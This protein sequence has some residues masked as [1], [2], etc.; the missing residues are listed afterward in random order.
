MTGLSKLTQLTEQAEHLI[1]GLMSGTSL[2]GLD[3]ALCRIKGRGK[4]ATVTLEH[5][6]TY[7][8]TEALQRKIREIFAQEAVK[9]S[10]V[11]MLNSRIAI[12]HARM[13]LE[14]L[15]K[16]GV[17]PTEVDCIASHGQTIYHAPKRLHLKAHYSNS[18]LQIGDGDHLA[19]RTGIITISDFRQKHVAAGGEGAPLV[20]YGDYILFSD[21]S[22]D[23]IL[24]NIGGIAN[25]T[26]LPASQDATQVRATDT[27]PGNTLMD[28]A[29]RHYLPPL[30]FDDE[31][32]IAA[33]GTVQIDLLKTMKTHPF[34]LNS[35]PKTTGQELF[36]MKFFQD[37]Q[38]NSDTL[39]ISNADLLATLT[40][41]TAETI[42]DAIQ[43]Y[44]PNWQN[45]AIYLSGGG[46][47]NLTLETHLHELLQPCK[48]KELRT[49]GFPTHAKEAT[50]FALLAHQTL[51]S[52]VLQLGD[53]DNYIPAVSLGKISLPD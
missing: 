30:L 2:D 22:E 8:Y 20:V 51:T 7:P 26:Y 41:F 9:L 39:D 12:L 17:A 19:Y 16:W 34:F 38:R 5:F 6:S 27:G 23:R 48:F 53:K 32:T 42:A 14:T 45:C 36:N 4:E 28:T 46:A 24:L 43:E 44:I 50:L 47:K 11:C 35:F 10:T 18:T 3:I 25:L 33:A 40:R 29:V 1:L 15:E 49:L 13:V 37:A 21:A 31:G 52:T